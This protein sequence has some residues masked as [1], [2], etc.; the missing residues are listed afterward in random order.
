MKPRSGKPWKIAL[1]KKI[2]AHNQAKRTALPV[3]I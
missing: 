1:E 3:R 2:V